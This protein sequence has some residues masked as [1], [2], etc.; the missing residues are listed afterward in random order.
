M[1][2]AENPFLRAAISLSFSIAS[3]NAAAKYG[4]AAKWRGKAD[5]QPFKLSDAA[6]S[7]PIMRV[8]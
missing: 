4:T 2:A 1:K 8:I 6:P 3:G 5:S 7:A